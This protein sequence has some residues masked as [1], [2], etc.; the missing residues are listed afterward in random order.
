M[1]HLAPDIARD[2]LRADCANCFGFCCVALYF[3]ASDG[4]PVDKEAG[5]PCPNLQTDFRCREYENLS[6][7]GLKGC[8]AYDCFGAGQKVAKFTY[9]MRDWRQA[10]ESAERMFRVFLAIRQ[11]HEMLWYLSEAVGLEKDG[12]LHSELKALLSETERLTS[13]DADSLVTLDVDTHR[14]A[15]NALLRQISEAVRNRARSSCRASGKRMKSLGR[16]P[17]L[18]GQD[19]RERD[20]RG[21]DLRGAYLIAGDLR[22]VDLAGADLIGADLRDADLRGAD[23]TNAIFLTQIQ[24]NA[25][26]GD[27]DTKL[28]RS[29]LR[30]THW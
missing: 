3:S 27:S 23:L 26:K 7:I 8:T 6:R 12:N 1:E 29:L 2:N 20:L 16:G 21:A 25:A 19:L 17:D 11:L 24:I 28:P 14:A 4:F 30:P 22:G 9:G 15:V 5:K 10:P 18:V 13:L